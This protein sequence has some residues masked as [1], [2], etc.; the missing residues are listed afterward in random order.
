MLGRYAVCV[1]IAEVPLV[2]ASGLRQVVLVRV[3]S[4]HNPAAV[5]PVVRA[6]LA[7]GLGLALVA[8]PLSDAVLK[9]LFGEQF[10]GTGLVLVILLAATAFAIAASLQNR[11]LIAIGAGGWRTVSQMVGLGVTLVGL[12]IV[13]NVLG[14]GLAG[15]ALVSLAAYWSVFAASYIALRRLAGFAPLNK[16]QVVAI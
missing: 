8:L 11:C 7:A 16:N 13:V 10:G 4:T 6:V 15:I 3:S 2:V 12:P 9:F 5:L 1:A 14:A